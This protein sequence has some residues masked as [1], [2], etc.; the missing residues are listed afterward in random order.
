MRQYKEDCFKIKA[1]CILYEPD[2]V[3]VVE[4]WLGSYVLDRDRDGGELLFMLLVTS[5]SQSSPLVLTPLSF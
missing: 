2:I 1:N 4:T 3:C 5:P